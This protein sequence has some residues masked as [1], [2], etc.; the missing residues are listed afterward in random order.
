MDEVMRNQ[1]KE[2]AKRY[3]EAIESFVDK[4]RGDP[5]V[6]AVIVYGS[7]ARGAVWER[8]D[9]D[10]DVIIRDQK[11]DKKSFC[12]Y[13]DNILLNIGI[14]QRSDMRRY[15]EKTLTGSVGHSFATTSKVVYTT[16]E[17]INEYFE[18]NKKIGQADVEK[19]I[20]FSIM[21]LLGT[22]EKVEKWIVTIND[23]TYARYYL[24]IAA[25]GVAKIE[26]SSHNEVPTRE[27]IRQAE[28]LNPALMKKFYHRPLAG[29]MT[30]EEILATLK[31][32]DD[33][34]MTHIDAVLNVVRGL[35]GDGE[36]K[37]GTQISN[38]YN[39]SMHDLHGILDWL[40]DKNYLIKLSQT[41]RITPKSRLAVEEA[42]FMMP[43]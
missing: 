16:D 12:L 34:L 36:I 29:D 35:F 20:F 41:I 43:V 42:A 19:S 2:L 15:M 5:N 26:V 27:A 23:L 31:D 4:V 6:I 18:E 39:A 13:E 28:R 30:R 10:I 9:I 22:M 32:M 24:T 11:L 17:T 37:T 33:Y 3:H 1:S 38:Y 21:G 40:C 14:G 25:D 8:S 7:A